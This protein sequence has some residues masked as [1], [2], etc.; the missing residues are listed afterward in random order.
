MIFRPKGE[1]IFILL[2]KISQSK[3]P[4]KWQFYIM[5]QPDKMEHQIFIFLK[6]YIPATIIIIV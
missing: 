1:I 3:T 4:S 6:A 2:H 5:Q